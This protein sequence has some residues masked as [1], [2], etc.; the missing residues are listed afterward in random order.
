[1]K[2]GMKR[3]WK[4]ELL[5]KQVSDRLPPISLAEHLDEETSLDG[6]SE[7]D[8]TDLTWHDDD[9]SDDYDGWSETP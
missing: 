6:F 9:Q 2:I 7:S 3:M 5:F 8:K 4:K 1:M